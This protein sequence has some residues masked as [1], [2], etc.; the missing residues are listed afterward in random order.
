MLCVLGLLAISFIGKQEDDK[1]KI[2]KQVK[3]SAKVNVAD[4]VILPE[5]FVDTLKKA[6]DILSK[7]LSSEEF[8]KELSKRS[9]ADSAFSKTKKTCFERIYDEKGRVSGLGVYENITRN[10]NIEIE[11]VIKKYKD[12]EKTSVMGFATFCVNRI[13]SHDYW[14]KNGQH[15][16][17]RFVRHLAH[18]YT[19]VCG[20]K[21]DKLLP[22]EHKFKKGDDPA[23]GVGSIVGDIMLDWTKKGLL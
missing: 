17:L 5:G 20:Y 4:N 3:F 1:I 7:I 11:W 19:H 8:K 13:T 2:A 14:I 16:S 18:E 12:G 15:L 9:F 23:M 10:P 22:K 6:E 21:H